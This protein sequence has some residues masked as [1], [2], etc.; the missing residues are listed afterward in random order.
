MTP[1]GGQRPTNLLTGFQSGVWIG[2]ENNTRAD[3]TFPQ[4]ASQ[5]MTDISAGGMNWVSV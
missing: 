5:V 3:T 2:A 1:V 4:M